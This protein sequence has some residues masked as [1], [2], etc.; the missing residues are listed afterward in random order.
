MSK[1]LPLL[2][3]I[4]NKTESAIFTV[5]VYFLA[6]IGAS[7]SRCLLSVNMF[8]EYLCS[9][10]YKMK[11]T[12]LVNRPALLDSFM[13]NACLRAKSILSVEK[14]VTDI[15]GGDTCRRKIST[16]M[17]V[18]SFSKVCPFAEQTVSIYM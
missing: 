8:I 15:Y 2:I 4:L 13:K 10:C 9:E 6:L 11:T 18:T 3:N 12:F 1:Y 5:Q 14:Y 7:L 17:F 16:A